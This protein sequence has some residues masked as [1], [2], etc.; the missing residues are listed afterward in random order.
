MTLFSQQCAQS[1]LTLIVGIYYQ[2]KGAFTLWQSRN[3]IITMLQTKINF[4]WRRLVSF[5]Q[6]CNSKHAKQFIIEK[7][8]HNTEFNFQSFYKSLEI[9]LFTQQ[10]RYHQSQSMLCWFRIGSNQINLIGYLIR[11]CGPEL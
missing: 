11:Y 7:E 1:T 9:K 8:K 3:L 2:S 4:S 5:Y 6:N 10:S